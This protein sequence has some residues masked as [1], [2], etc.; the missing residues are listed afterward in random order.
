MVAQVLGQVFHA[1]RFTVHQKDLL[2]NILRRF[3]GKIH[4]TAV[5]GMSAE[6]I[7][8]TQFGADHHRAPVHGHM[9]GSVRQLPSKAAFGQ[10][11]NKKNTGLGVLELFLEVGMNPTAVQ[12]A[13]CRNQNRRP[14]IRSN[15]AALPHVLNKAQSFKREHIPVH[16]DHI[17]GLL[18]EPILHV[19]VDL[20]AQDG[21]G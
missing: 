14:I 7:G 9:A 19:S 16:F 10:I 11:A 17:A 1:V 2:Q 18:A 15:F 3:G 6:D 20:G 4:Q 8:I 12:H 13:R 21:H 5:V